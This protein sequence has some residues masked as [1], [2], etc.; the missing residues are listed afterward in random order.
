MYFRKLRG[1]SSKSKASSGRRL[2]SNSNS[3]D[4]TAGRQRQRRDWGF[5]F[6]RTW[7]NLDESQSE[8]THDAAVELGNGKSTQTFVHSGQ[9]QDYLADGIHFS[10]S[11]QQ[12]AEVRDLETMQAAHVREGVV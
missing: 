4:S 10:T 1:D 6:S 3:K 8:L 7:R 5:N 2:V 9:P 11:L 12:H